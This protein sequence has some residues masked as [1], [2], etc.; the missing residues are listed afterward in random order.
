MSRA[1]F[2][3]LP[4]A[5]LFSKAFRHASNAGFLSSSADFLSPEDFRNM[6]K[7]L[8]YL[9]ARFFLPAKDFRRLPNDI[10]LPA[11]AI[12]LSGADGN[13][14]GKLAF[15]SNAPPI[16]S[17]TENC[18]DCHTELIVLLKSAN[19]RNRPRCLPRLPAPSPGASGG[20]FPGGRTKSRSRV[21]FR[22]R[23]RGRLLS[24]CASGL[25]PFPIAQNLPKSRDCACSTF[26]EP[27]GL[28]DS[29]KA[30]QN[31]GMFFFLVVYVSER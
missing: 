5:F 30:A 10:F 13:G 28:Y 24:N 11:A 9:R 17:S 21:S 26:P 7:P 19:P 15:H 2:P 20:K 4:A 25:N 6:S 22:A 14:P 12:L 23:G 3:A 31:S 1:V 16:I 27:I 8:P 18:R 29:H